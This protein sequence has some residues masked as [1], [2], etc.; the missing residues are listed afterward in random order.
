MVKNRPAR[1]GDAGDAGDVGSVPGLGRSLGEGNGYSLQYFCLGNPMDRGAWWAMIHGVPKKSG[2]VSVSS[3][4]Q[5][6]LTLCS[7]MDCS[8]P[9]FPVHHHLPELTQTSL[10]IEPVMPS[11]HLILCQPLLLP[12]SI[13]P[14]IGSFAMS[15]FF[16]SGGQSIGV[17]ASLSVVPM[18]TED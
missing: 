15:Q 5:S 6:C 4:T 13:F 14:S 8:M 12:L 9:A 3:V 11:N 17:S 16:T 18:N 10:S 2:I 7:P 1:V